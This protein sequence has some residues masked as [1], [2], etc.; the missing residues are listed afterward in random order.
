MVR[1][2]QRLA[3]PDFVV[4][5]IRIAQYDKI[6]GWRPK[7]QNFKVWGFLAEIQQRFVTG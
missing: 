1:A 5:F 7:T 2:R 6:A 3:P 4:Y